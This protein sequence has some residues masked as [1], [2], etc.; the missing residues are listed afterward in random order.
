MMTINKQLSRYSAVDDAM[1]ISIG[2][3]AGDVPSSEARDGYLGRKPRSSIDATQHRHTVLD[4]LS[5]YYN[6]RPPLLLGHIMHTSSIRK[7]KTQ[8]GTDHV[9]A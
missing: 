5:E 2:P 6:S 9:S 1:Q 3:A 7:H 4:T 8:L